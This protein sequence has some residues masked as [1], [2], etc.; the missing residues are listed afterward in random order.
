MYDRC[1]WFL[2]VTMPSSRALC[3]LL[4]SIKK[5]FSY[6]YKSIISSS[7][8]RD[9]SFFFFFFF[10]QCIIKQLLASVFV[11]SRIINVSVGVI[12]PSRRLTLITPTSTLI[13]LDFTKTSSKNCLLNIFVKKFEYF[14]N[15][16]ANDSLM[17]CTLRILTSKLGSL[18]ELARNK[19]KMSARKWRSLS[20]WVNNQSRGSYIADTCLS[21]FADS[22]IINSQKMIKYF[23]ETNDVIPVSFGCLAYFA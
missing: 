15:Q 2:R 17:D 14:P 8:C 11:I 13:I 3:C 18:D 6:V 23:S 10:V 7:Y 12:S 16:G 9:H 4:I 5:I 19:M 20:D 1:A 21:I 22:T